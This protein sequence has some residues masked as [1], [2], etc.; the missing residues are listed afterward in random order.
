MLC[1]GFNNDWNCE[2]KT[3]AILEIYRNNKKPF[4][5]GKGNFIWTFC[6]YSS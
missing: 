1:K 2:T 6:F 4:S 3:K 5:K